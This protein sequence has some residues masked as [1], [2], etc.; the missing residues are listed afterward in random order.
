MH[1]IINVLQRDFSSLMLIITPC[2]TLSASSTLSVISCRNPIRSCLVNYS[3]GHISLP[4]K[5]LREQRSMDCVGCLL[6]CPVKINSRRRPSH[7]RRGGSFGALFCLNFVGVCSGLTYPRKWDLYG[8]LPHFSGPGKW[9]EC[10]D[11]YSLGHS[12]RGRPRCP[13]T[14][15]CVRN[16]FKRFGALEWFMSACSNTNSIRADS[17]SQRFQPGAPKWNKENEKQFYLL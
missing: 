4:N 2:T 1:V 15:G 13:P 3:C 12:I 8:R 16:A 11:G 7:K 10:G 5:N 17:L 6:D 14:F 9:N